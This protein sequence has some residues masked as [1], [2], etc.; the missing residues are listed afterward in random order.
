MNQ[1][2][3]AWVAPLYAAVTQRP[4]PEDVAKAALRHFPN[5]THKLKWWRRSLGR[6]YM[7]TAFSHPTPLTHTTNVLATLVGARPLI[8]EETFGP[9]LT[10]LLS[11]ARNSIGAEGALDFKADRLNREG[12]AKAGIEL[13]NRRYNRI[14]RLVDFLEKEQAGN[15][16]YGEFCDL[17]RGAKTGILSHLSREDFARD[18]KTALF[19]AYMGARQGMRAK[20]TIDPQDRAFDDLGDALLKDLAESPTTHWFAAA[21]VFPRAD[22]LAHLSELERLT[23]LALALDRMRLAAVFLERLAKET[24]IDIRKGCIVQRGQDSSS[25]NA[26]AGAWNKAR[27]FWIGLSHSLGLS[28]DAMLPGKVP[29][30]IAADV[31]AWHRRVG[32]P[33]HPDEKIVAELPMPWDVF[34]HEAECTTEQVAAACARH[35]VDPEKTGWTAPRAR[36]TIE[37]WRPTPELVHGVVI[38]NPAVAHAMRRMGY[39]AGPAKWD[40]KNYGA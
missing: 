34:L 18:P 40:R 15:V 23:L 27:E 11:Q 6:S 24:G 36:H 14:F 13:S 39:F 19:V 16:R 33:P 30:L 31:A 9:E 35:G 1:N 21:H 5:L 28:F 3:P 26:S 20:F 25:W 8:D 29:R 4:R 32:N 2:E 22:V 17:L 12:R 10:A 38:A 37:T 7:P